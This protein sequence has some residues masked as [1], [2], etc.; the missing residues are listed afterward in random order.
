[1]TFIV[2]LSAEAAAQFRK[3]DKPIQEQILK[4]LRRLAENPELAKPLSYKLKN[5]RSE[6]IG[7]YRAMFSIHQNR[8]LVA[9]IE[10]R[11]TVYG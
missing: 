4:R 9:K 5:N 10:H 2:E 11:D 8:L 3:L 6:H 7:K 1:M